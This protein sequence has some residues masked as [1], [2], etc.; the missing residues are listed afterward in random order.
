M[1]VGPMHLS[2]AVGTPCVA[3]YSAR[4]F[5]RQWTPRGDFN[6]I[7]Y[8][9]TDCAGCGL[10]LCIEQKKKCIL[11]ITVDEVQ[12]SALQLLNSKRGFKF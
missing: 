8:H 7:L 2:A 1:T 3:I 12:N 9:K 11:S 4:N 6:K 10:E 5:L